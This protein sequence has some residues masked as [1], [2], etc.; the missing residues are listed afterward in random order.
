MLKMFHIE[1]RNPQ[2][3][4]I[5]FQDLKSHDLEE[6]S[7]NYEKAHLLRK[8]NIAAK[9]EEATVVSAEITTCILPSS[10][11]PTQCGRCF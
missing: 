11:L 2:P 9:F 5:I 10:P 3:I 7:S 8:G 4:Y 1:K 6:L